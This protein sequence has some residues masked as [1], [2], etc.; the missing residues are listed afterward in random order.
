MATRQYIG[1]R[2]VPKFYTNSV[3]GSTQWESNV[4]YEPLIYVTL[5]NGHMYISK[6][7]VPATV[8]S[9]ASNA[10]YWLDIGSYNG[11]IEEL[12]NEVE[13]LQNKVK[14]KAAIFGNSFAAG[15]GGVQG[16]YYALEPLFDDISWHGASG[17]GFLSYTGAPTGFKTFGQI[18]SSDSIDNDVT[19]VIVLG[20]LGES[21]SMQN[22][23]TRD[24]VTAMK[25]AIASFMSECATKFPNAKKYTYIYCG[26]VNSFH[27]VDT[28]TASG[29]SDFQAEF[30]VH[31]L[32]PRCV[33]ESKLIY[34]GWAG[35]DLLLQPSL[36]QADNTHPNQDGT[37]ILSHN[38]I[39]ILQGKGMVYKPF[40]FKDENVTISLGDTSTASVKIYHKVY[41]DHT[42]QE[43][44][45][46]SGNV[47]AAENV[48][49]KNIV[50]VDTA[51]LSFYPPVGSYTASGGTLGG[52]RKIVTKAQAPTDSFCNE[53][54]SVTASTR[55]DN[56]FRSY[57]NTSQISGSYNAPRFP[58]EWRIS[59]DPL[60]DSLT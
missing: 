36:F 32:M 44:V 22:Y 47:S 59:H 17:A 16:I 54:I 60:D 46:G 1:A 38:C 10:N 9:P 37:D 28:T 55:A 31:M 48:G 53:T 56:W 13:A 8:G 35:W 49:N 29:Y 45:Q 19:D 25:T 7:Q 15:V 6:K 23:S 3:D 43:L 4:V 20:A 50:V 51:T 58:T 18:A 21:R 40:Y 2:Y 33:K 11:F 34:G 42:E 27:K 57:W 39:G 30:W 52:Q 24:W 41:P 5:T 26:N 12:E 14:T